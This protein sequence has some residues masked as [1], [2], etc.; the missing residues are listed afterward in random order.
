MGPSQQWLCQDRT[1]QNKGKLRGLT[2][3]VQVCSA[4]KSGHAWAESQTGRTSY[5]SSTDFPL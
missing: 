5:Q 1:S 4:F 3:A 2:S